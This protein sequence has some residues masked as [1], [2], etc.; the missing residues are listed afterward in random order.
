MTNF[1]I[2]SQKN[3]LWLLKIFYMLLATL[4]ALCTKSSLELVDLESFEICNRTQKLYF[5]WRSI[6]IHRNEIVINQSFPN[7]L[8]PTCRILYEKYYVPWIKCHM[9]YLINAVCIFMYRLQI[10]KPPFHYHRITI[11]FDKKGSHSKY[12]S[13]A[14]QREKSIMNYVQ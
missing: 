8:S 1:V 7:K 9:R 12:F 13:A 4:Y 5:L 14:C 10:R 6:F 11:S 2:L 3:I